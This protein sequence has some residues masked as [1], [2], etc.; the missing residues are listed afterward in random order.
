MSADAFCSRLDSFE[1]VQFIRGHRRDVGE[2]R[3][4][5]G[6]EMLPRLFAEFREQVHVE[7]RL[8]NHSV[9]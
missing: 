9:G 6:S 1:A 7:P 3:N 5:F 4:P 2:G 8:R